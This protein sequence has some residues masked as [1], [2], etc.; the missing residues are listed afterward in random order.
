VEGAV[1]VNGT[2]GA[3][4]NAVAAAT[5][6]AAKG[7]AGQ[8]LWLTPCVHLRTIPTE[9][10]GTVMASAKAVAALAAKGF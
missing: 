3:L 9:W 1:G 2:I 4:S 6:G 7:A 5:A 10:S 8:V